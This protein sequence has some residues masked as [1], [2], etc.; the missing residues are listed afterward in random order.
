MIDEA[1]RRI[2]DRQRDG[3]TKVIFLSCE[4]DELA[5][6]LSRD[7]GDR[8][9]LTG[10]DPIGEMQTVLEAR[11]PTYRQLADFVYDVTS[12]SPETAAVEIERLV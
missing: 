8:P 4:I 1:R 10:T 5:R 12:V 6:R 11:E 3:A 2:E 9:T 7:V